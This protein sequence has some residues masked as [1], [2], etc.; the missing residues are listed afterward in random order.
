MGPRAEDILLS[1]K[2][3]SAEAK[4]Y[5]T[6]KRK[7]EEHFGARV[8]IVLERIRFNRRVQQNEG[9]VSLQIS[10]SWQRY[11]ILEH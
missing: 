4:S 10:I 7:F 11:A 6:I 1:F 9:T 3:S 5:N 2:L 8:N